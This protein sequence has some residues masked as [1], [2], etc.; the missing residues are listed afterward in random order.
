MSETHKLNQST[1]IL[2]SYILYTPFQFTPLT[3]LFLLPLAVSVLRHLPLLVLC[4][5]H[6]HLANVSAHVLV[7]ELS[8]EALTDP[9]PAECSSERSLSSSSGWC[10]GHSQQLLCFVSAVP[11]IAS[12]LLWK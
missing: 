4:V 12:G 3:L 11:R 6:D 8:Q 1:L 10:R 2:L 5:L 7:E 9:Q